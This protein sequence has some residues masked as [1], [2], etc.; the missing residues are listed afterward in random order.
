MN[1]TTVT[2][3]LAIDLRADRIA[4]ALFE[5][6]GSLFD[7]GAPRFE[8]PR[9]ARV[10]V[11]A[12]L[13]TIRPS[14]VVLRRLRP[15]STRRRPRWK[16][17]LRVIQS[18]AKWLDLPVSWVTERALKK[19]FGSFGCRNK[20]QA[21]ELLAGKFPQIAWKLPGARKSYE[22]EPWTICYFDAISLGVVYLALASEDSQH[23]APQ[24]QV[25]SPASK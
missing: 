22:P 20:F 14:V 24:D 25:L 19:H 1:A 18:E 10:R 7:F 12:L 11:A 21:A 4:Y 3:I 9:T 2:R 16:S 6:S 13:G 15:R 5:A 23:V 8:S 17:A